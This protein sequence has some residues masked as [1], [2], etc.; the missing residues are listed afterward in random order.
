MSRARLQITTNVSRFDNEKVEWKKK[1]N[2]IRQASKKRE[3]GK[4]SCKCSISILL[5]KPAIYIP[6]YEHDYLEVQKG[7]DLLIK[8]V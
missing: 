7:P 8:L 1:E 6:S 5:H 2:A 4:Q 3:V